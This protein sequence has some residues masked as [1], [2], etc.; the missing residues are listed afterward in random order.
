MRKILSFLL[1]LYGCVMF[2]QGGELDVPILMQDGRVV[3][4]S[5]ILYDSGGF[6]GN[7]GNDET[8][9]MT[10]CPE[11]P[12]DFIQLDFLSFATEFDLDKLTIYDGDNVAAGDFG[13]SISGE[14]WLQVVRA[15]AANTT[16]CLTLVF[17]SDGDTTGPGFA[18][19]ISCFGACQEIIPTIVNTVP[20]FDPNLI[21]ECGIGVIKACIGEELTF[22][23]SANFETSGAGA[24]YI[25]DFRNG[26]G[27]EGEVVS[28]TFDEIGA[29][30]V[31]LSV[32]DANGC[33]SGEI[34][35]FTVQVSAFDETTFELSSDKEEYCLGEIAVLGAIATPKEFPFIPPPILAGTTFLPD[36]RGDVYTTTIEVNQYCLDDRLE[37]PSQIKICLNLEHSYAGDLDIKITAPNGVTVNLFLQAGGGTYFGHPIDVDANLDPGVGE[38]YCFDVNANVTLANA[39]RTPSTGTRNGDMFTPGTYLPVGDLGDLVGTELNGNWSI[40][41]IDHLASDNGYIFQWNIEFA[42]E[43]VPGDLSFTPVLAAERWLPVPGLTEVQGVYYF[44]PDAPGVYELFYEVTDDFNCTY[45]S[46]EPL[47]VDFSST[48]IVGRPINLLECVDENGEA[49]FNLRDVERSLTTNPNYGFSYFNNQTDAILNLA[50]IQDVQALSIDDSPRT[51]WVRIFDQTGETTCIAIENFQLIINNCMIQVNEL[52]DLSVCVN[53]GETIGIFDLTSQ[54]EIAFDNTPGYSVTYYTSQTDAMEGINEVPLGNLPNF[55]GVEAQVI[56]VRV[57]N[58]LDNQEFGT[59][60]F[61]LLLNENPPILQVPAIIGCPLNDVKSLGEFHLSLNNIALTAGNSNLEVTYYRTEMEAE[62]GGAEGLLQDH[63]ISGAATIWARIENVN[64]GCYTVRSLELLVVA[65]P[66]IDRNAII[67]F[68]D[69]N[70]DGIGDFDLEDI[71]RIIL[72]RAITPDLN[73][74]Y[75]ISESNALNGIGAFLNPY[76]NTTPYNQTIYVRMAYHNTNCFEVAPIR[77]RVNNKPNIIVPTALEACVNSINEE[78]IY[79]LRVKETEILNGLNPNNYD[80]TYHIQREHAE[81]GFPIVQN[82]EGFSNLLGGLV[83]IRVE[84]INTGCFEVVTLVLRS[85][86]MPNVPFAL[87]SF[88]LCDLGGDGFRLF[89]LN[90]RVQQIVNGQLGLNVSFYANASEAINDENRLPA[91][92]QNVVPFN[93]T[94]FVRVENAVTGCYVVRILNLTVS[95]LPVLNI[96]EIPVEVCSLGEGGQGIFD[97]LS[98][99][100]RL[101]NGVGNVLISFYETESNANE[102]VNRILVP[103]RYNNL[104]PSNPIVWV[105]GETRG[106][107]YV[108]KALH[109]NVVQAPVIPI[110]L[111]NI[112]LCD[113]FNNVNQNTFDLTIQNQVILNTQHDNNPNDLRVSYYS[114]EDG[115]IGGIENQITN[116]TS[117]IPNSNPQLIWVRVDNMSTK[118]YSISSFSIEKNEALTLIQPTPITK[119]QLLLPNT[120]F[121]FFDLTEREL[122]I[123]GGQLIFGTEFKYYTSKNNALNNRN[124]IANPEHYRNTINPQTIW[125]VVTNMKGCKSIISLNI[126]VTPLPSVNM[127]PLPLYKCEEIAGQGL[128]EFDLKESEADI[129]NH[130]VGLKFEYYESEEE[131]LNGINEILFSSNWISTSGTIWVRI[132]SNPIDI[133]E[134]CSVILPL[135]LKVVE[136][137]AIPHLKP[138]LACEVD[139]DGFYTFNLRDKYSEILA[140]RRLQDYNIMFFLSQNDAIDGIVTPMPLTYTN[141]VVSRQIIWVRLEHKLS[142]CYYVAPLIL[143]VEEQIFAYEIDNPEPICDNNDIGVPV[144]DGMTVINLKIHDTAIIGIQNVDVA[145]LQVVYFASEEDFLNNNPILDPTQFVNTTSPQEIIAAVKHIDP[146]LFCEDIVRFVVEVYKRPE[147]LPIAGGYICKDFESGEITP[148]LIDSNLDSSLYNFEWLFNDEIIIGATESF[149]E[150]TEVGVYTIRTYD[151]VTGCVSFNSESTNVVTVNP[152]TIIIE[153][154]FGNRDQIIDEGIQTIIVNVSEGLNVYPS[155]VYEY[156]LN[157]GAYQKSNVFHNV[158]AGDHLIWVRD[159]ITGACAVSKVVSVMNYPKFFTPNGDGFN[160]TWNVLGLKNQP[161]AKVYIFDRSG[162][163]LK[164][165]SPLGEGWDGTYGGRP[166]PSTDYWFSVEYVDFNGYGREFKG[167]FSLKR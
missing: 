140:G 128:A 160:D 157:D 84:N 79:D 73:I 40:T 28:T 14:D 61:R 154:D 20:A 43:L 6:E 64:T 41:V 57:E 123:L 8:I 129:S 114:T 138:L 108:V 109:L 26:T 63:F 59:Q 39:P 103:Q 121:E 50:G 21:P 90:G 10:I 1:F 7:Y 164:Q 132:Y 162:K 71:S 82:S 23:G 165:L 150:A 127:T 99:V 75:Y 158:E 42:E 161:G 97:L 163:L 45:V 12:D 144:N 151:K 77:L 30:M 87:E 117:F 3:A 72:G 136:Q 17:E 139:T 51:V 100:N 94:I 104:D 153:E 118:C 2:S 55:S 166:M 147:V 74:S 116:S 119:C 66:D 130:S 24:R 13:G 156:A 145:G 89:N 80:F 53:E 115:A 69:T 67:D 88:D 131:A 102:R 9:V 32:I 91:L 60:S 152:F 86:L 18:A 52:P 5:G 141:L 37:D 4:C 143:Q 36:G 148:F 167:H 22:S 135:E 47:I 125:I 146:D 133:N 19:R 85:N 44:S 11:D 120:G 76:R 31:S 68:C 155:G 113:D 70:N 111:Q 65:L 16:G 92:Y 159:R 54:T 38:T 34:A 62:L 49:T 46:P 137:P 56:F 106:G 95:P 35:M 33:I 96:P 112:V 101:Q 105:R 29:Y 134:Q 107:C 149:Y 93:Q 124:A 25:W 48:V 81:R 122:Q 27:A 15:T 78:V 98:L 126:R 58:D 110:D 83:W 142:G